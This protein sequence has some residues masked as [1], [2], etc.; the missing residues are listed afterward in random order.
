MP[1]VALPPGGIPWDR[2]LPLQAADGVRLRGAIWHGG[3]RGLALLL[4]GRTE[5]LEKCAVS[6]A[7]LVQRGFSVA[8]IDWRGQGLSQRLLKDPL[9][10]HVE[11]FT[12][13]HLDLQALM[14]APEVKNLGPP[15]LML[16]HSMGGAI[17][18]GAIA[19]RIVAPQAVALSAPMLGIRLGLLGRIAA[20]L[21][22]APA[23]ALGLLDRWPPFAPR[24]PYVFEGYR[25]NV[26]TSDQAVFDWMADALRNAPRLQ[27]ASPTMGWMRT[28]LDEADY[29]AQLGPLTTPALMM[30]GSAEKVVDAGAIRAA[31][32]RLSADL[33]EIDG[34]RHEVLVESPPLRAQAWTAIDRFLQ[35]AEL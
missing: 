7:E 24:Q 16:A 3:D 23:K 14:A 28:A 34:A 26:L 27:L 33:L 21:L 12:D 20:G 4:S 25:N 30:L 29:L 6:A 17:G 18:L 8:S 11:A 13:F 31:A 19:R 5:F 32:S 10:G 9:K 1:A 2:D 35:R 15:R 22:L